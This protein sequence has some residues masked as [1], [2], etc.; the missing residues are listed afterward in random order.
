[1]STYELEHHEPDES[2]VEVV[3]LA[4]ELDVTNASGLERRLETEVRSDVPLVVDLNR[5]VFIDSAALHCF[6]RLAR[7]RGRSRLALVVEPGAPIARALDI[8]DLGGAVTVAPTLEAARAALI[9]A[10]TT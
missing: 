7:G 10:Q 4:G 2:G 3:A 8:V 5:V 1:V 6:F 9:G